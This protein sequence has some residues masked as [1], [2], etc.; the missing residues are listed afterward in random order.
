MWLV[1][2]RTEVKDV[3]LQGKLDTGD[4]SNINRAAAAQLPIAKRQIVV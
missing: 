3:W 2:S 4:R 1:K